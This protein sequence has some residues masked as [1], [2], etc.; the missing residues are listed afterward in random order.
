[1]A[2]P[3]QL[4]VTL[5]TTIAITSKF[6]LCLIQLVPKSPR[7]VAKQS[8]I[9]RKNIFRLRA[10]F[11]F[12]GPEL[13]ETKS[14]TILARWENFCLSCFPLSRGSLCRDSTRPLCVS[15]SSHDGGNY[16]M[17]TAATS[18]IRTFLMNVQP[19]V[20]KCFWTSCRAAFNFE[21]RGPHVETVPQCPFKCTLMVAH[22]C[23]SMHDW[24]RSDIFFHTFKCQAASVS[25]TSETTV[26]ITV[27]SFE[28]C[29]GHVMNLQWP[30]ITCHEKS[31]K[32]IKMLIN[33]IKMA[34][35]YICLSHHCFSYTWL[36]VMITE[37]MLNAKQVLNDLVLLLLKVRLCFGYSDARHHF[38]DFFNT[39]KHHIDSHRCDDSGLLINFRGTCENTGTCRSSSC[40]WLFLVAYHSRTLSA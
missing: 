30:G 40:S 29:M 31:F 14:N 2:K 17:S 13:V 3:Q 12:T 36:Y 18:F 8:T 1:M 34:Q 19:R 21:S 28:W 26:K 20:Y 15:C 37:F 24:R 38:D 11:D 22:W 7:C 35:F 5:S 9:R 23:A 25:K 16:E 27:I 6:S 39:N 4:T 33:A 32:S 10:D